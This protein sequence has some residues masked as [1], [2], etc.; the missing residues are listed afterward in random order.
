M[1]KKVA[2]SIILTLVFTAV[3]TVPASAQYNPAPG[4]V[5]LPFDLYSP[6][7]LAGGADS[8]AEGVPSASV[9]NP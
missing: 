6:V 3:L 4:S 8:V 5:T 2:R 1:S 9:L 7:F